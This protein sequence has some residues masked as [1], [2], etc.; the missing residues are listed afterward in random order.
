MSTANSPDF[1]VGRVAFG[2]AGAAGHW[3]STPAV[4]HRY[5]RGTRAVP[6][7]CRD[8]DAGCPVLCIESW[9]ALPIAIWSEIQGESQWWYCAIGGESGVEA[10]SRTFAGAVL[11]AS[12]KARAKWDNCN[13]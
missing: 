13:S 9:E 11:D 10:K 7:Q 5:P 1:V 3:G 4:S 6:Q 8:V 12:V 2:R